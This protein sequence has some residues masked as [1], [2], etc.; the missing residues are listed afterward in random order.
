MRLIDADALA[1]GGIKVSSGYNADGIIMIPMRDVNKS[2]KNAPTID[3]EPVKRGRWID[4]RTEIVCSSCEARY[5]DEVVFMNR[6]CKHDDLKY[7][8]SCGA[9]MDLVEGGSK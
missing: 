8:P 9:K 2:I 5:S 4:D 3:A 7:C 1:N 6:D